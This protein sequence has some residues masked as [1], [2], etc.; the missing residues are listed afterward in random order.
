[1]QQSEPGEVEND[2]KK[3]QAKR[4][5]KI[6]QK[7]HALFW[8]MLASATV[9][10]TDMVNVALYS[11]T[12][13]RKALN[14]SLMCL[15]FNA[16]LMVY[17]AIYLPRFKGIQ[18]PFKEVDHEG[19]KWVWLDIHHPKAIPTMTAVGLLCII[20]TMVAFWPEWGFFTPLLVGFLMM[21]VILGIH[22]VPSC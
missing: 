7:I 11:E 2:A 13:N 6:Q 16:L 9:Y 8:V 18:D 12:I 19:K 1:M 20:L 17:I 3:V 21:G 5:E 10:Y 15:I 14:M 22:F 4:S